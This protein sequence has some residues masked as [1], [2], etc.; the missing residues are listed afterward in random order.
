MYISYPCHQKH[1]LFKVCGTVLNSEYNSM[2]SLYL[3]F[4]ADD[5]CTVASV[6]DT[7]ETLVPEDNFEDEVISFLSVADLSATDYGIAAE[8]SLS[9]CVSVCLSV[10]RVNH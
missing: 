6:A 3:L 1:N 9:V 4:P 10:W 5:E 7:E 2:A 8:C